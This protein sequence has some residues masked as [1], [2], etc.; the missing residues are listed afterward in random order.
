[1]DLS[2]W[3][4]IL[5]SIGGLALV[6][7][8]G[9]GIRLLVM[10]TIQQRRE[11]MNRQINERLRT[12]IAA[13]RTLGGSFT[14]DLAV[15]PSHLRDLR[16][17]AIDADGDGTPD[18]AV[19]LSP[20]ALGSDRSRRIRDAVEASLADILL[21][22]TDEHVRLAERAASELVAGRKVHTHELVVA[23]RDYVREALQLD[24]IPSDVA[25]SIPFQGPTRPASSGGKGRGGGDG[26]RG[27]GGGRGGGGMGMGG[28]MAVGGIGLGVGA[29][30]AV[31]SGSDERPSG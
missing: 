12:L 29:G 23:L 17:P 27:G 19:D 15:D 28:G 6:T 1:M 22:G 21:L 3:H 5:V 9:V 26:E 14:G 16:Q 31:E 25:A 11:R 8:I 13:Y 20:E 30:A 2:S 10:M 4:G 24:P 18:R 7:L